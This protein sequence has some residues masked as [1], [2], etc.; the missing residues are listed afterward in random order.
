MA[1]AAVSESVMAPEE[2]LMRDMSSL[3]GL[4]A[5]ASQG[6]N[7]GTTTLDVGETYA[8]SVLEAADDYCCPG[9][10]IGTGHMDSSNPGSALSSTNTS[11]PS[12]YASSPGNQNSAY[13]ATESVTVSGHQNLE[14]AA[15][16]APSS[17]FAGLQDRIQSF[18]ASGSYSEA[19]I[20]AES[21][22]ADADNYCCPGCDIGT[23]HIDSSDA[24]SALVST[25]TYDATEA[26]GS[27]EGQS[28][29]YSVS[30]ESVSQTGNQNLEQA[31]IEGGDS[32]F[33]GLQDRIQSFDTGQ[34][35]AENSLSAESVVIEADNYCCPGCDI[36]T[37]HMDSSDSN[38]TLA[39]T[40]TYS[41]PEF[42]G[43][44]IQTTESSTVSEPTIQETNAPESMSS[45]DAVATSYDSVSTT[46]SLQQS[47]DLGDSSTMTSQLN[48][49]EQTT[50][51]YV[52]DTS[53][54]TGNSIES[55]QIF[56]SYESTTMSEVDTSFSTT[57][58]DQTIEAHI[59]SRSTSIEVSSNSTQMAYDENVISER[60]SIS[61]Q[62]ESGNVNESISVQ[63]GATINSQPESNSVVTSYSSGEQTGLDVAQ[64]NG[65]ENTLQ[66]SGTEVST[67]STNTTESIQS[68]QSYE[69]T[70]MSEV[71]TSFS[72]TSLDQ[73]IE[74]H[75]SSRSAETNSIESSS[76]T[77]QVA[78]E[79]STVTERSTSVESSAEIAGTGYETSID[80]F[81]RTDNTVNSY[82]STN[83]SDLNDIQANDLEQTIEETSNS[84]GNESK[85]NS[86]NA[87][88]QYE[89]NSPEESN[90]KNDSPYQ[91][92]NVIGEE[93]ETD[94][95]YKS[96]EHQKP[97]NET[98]ESV[99]KKE[100][101]RE[102]LE[103]IG[104]NK[105]SKTKKEVI[106]KQKEN[107]KG[108]KIVNRK[109]KKES[110]KK[111]EVTAKKSKISARKV[112]NKKLK[113]IKRA[114]SNPSA[115][116]LSSG[117]ILE[118][119]A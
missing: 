13:S 56:Q 80:Q 113:K 18:D 76:S 32:S 8:G 4:A 89:S 2:G 27:S 87:E 19:S 106:S 110:T 34:S 92:D 12:E 59:S 112:K 47:N 21:I 3:D 117:K 6:A 75:I 58:L 91:L 99:A 78:Y 14:Q 67:S 44:Q 70:T 73:T 111:K 109:I 69:S 71:D 83:P 1:Y 31:A 22:V 65:L 11:N 17:S 118:V 42:A 84:L 116:R 28:A 23:G 50:Q 40:D 25:S 53:S 119:A 98:R 79:S 72:T 9:C 66:Q 51:Q 35:Y 81:S 97:D 26:L 20:S 15:S 107:K 62:N 33:E 100:D 61:S 74:A 7:F 90:H 115:R 54:D 49:L 36:G 77:S 93:T 108:V 103:T 68:S 24:S 101:P 63:Y 10:D 30:A 105:E 39:S 37:G 86:I 45:I 46:S 82:S 96:R 114:I 85:G 16:N 5:R 60:G 95:K 41:A 102:R 57:S 88:Q 104:S 55:S 94:A 29:S 38:N 64:N 48:G 52:N 43:E